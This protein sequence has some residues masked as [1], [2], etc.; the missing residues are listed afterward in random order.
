[1]KPFHVINTRPL[2]IVHKLANYEDWKLESPDKNE[3]PIVAFTAMM[4]GV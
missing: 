2:G 1:M 3:Y 4:A